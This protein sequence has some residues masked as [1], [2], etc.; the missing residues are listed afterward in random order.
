MAG[1]TGRAYPAIGYPAEISTVA[2]RAHV[3][4]LGCLYIPMSIGVIIPMNSI[5]G[6]DRR[7]GSIVVMAELTAVVI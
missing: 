7:M 3:H 4:E 6:T 5:P 2:E 1:G